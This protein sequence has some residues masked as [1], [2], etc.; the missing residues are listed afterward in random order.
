M[1]GLWP[2][3]AGILG[4]LLARHGIRGVLDWTRPW[5]LLLALL[6]LFAG[7]QSGFRSFALLSGFT[8]AILFCVEGLHRTRIALVLLGVA[9]LGG[10]IVLPHAEKLPLTVQRSLTFLPGK[11]DWAAKASAEATWEWRVGMWKD[12]LP[13]VPRCL[14]RGKG[15]AFNARDFYRTVET[16]EAGNPLAGVILTQ[17]FH[18]GPLSILIPFGIYGAI[19]FV[20]FLVAGLRVLHRNWKFGDPALKNVNAL[21]LAA[22]AGRAVFFF[23]CFGSL[24]SDMAI[25]TGLLG[26]SVAL[27]G[28]GTPLAQAEATAT[29]VEL[30]TEY[31]KA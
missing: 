3:G 13:T 23:F 26:L 28:A 1:R 31:V 16:G 30:G 12:L 29:G 4:Y 14:F 2:F 7:L 5:R 17:N 11:F 22:F 9:L 25:F 8:Y 19:A 24:H 10:A 20:W 27:N 6:A 21:L 18:N 15:W